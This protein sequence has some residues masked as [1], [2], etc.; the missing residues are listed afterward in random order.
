MEFG[1]PIMKSILITLS[2]F[3]S[4]NVS[5]SEYMCSDYKTLFSNIRSDTNQP[6]Y[7]EVSRDEFIQITI[8]RRKVQVRIINK[9]DL[10]FKQHN[11]EIKD[12]NSNTYLDSG[13]SFLATLERP[14]I[15]DGMSNGEGYTNLLFNKPKGYFHLVL[16]KIN[17]VSEFY[18][19]TCKETNEKSI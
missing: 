6:R 7:D 17:W 8:K 3:I 15:A 5:A 11:L 12:Y 10:S 13:P 2:L 18:F 14:G 1:S 16:G 4:F 19:G 9:K